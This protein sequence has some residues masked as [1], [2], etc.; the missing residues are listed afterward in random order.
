MERRA[1]AYTII[2]ASALTAIAGAA[3]SRGRSELSEG[4]STGDRR[5]SLASRLLFLAG[6]AVLSGCA[7]NPNTGRNQLMALPA[8]QS[9]HANIAYAISS[10]GGATTVPLCATVLPSPP[11]TTSTTAPSACLSPAQRE[12]FARQVQRI[13]GELTEAAHALAPTLVARFEAFSIAVD[14]EIATGTVSNAGG[15]IALS[16]DL[17]A[18]DP[19]D[20]VVAFLIAREMGH[21]IARH[22][23]ENAGV[24]M[25][26]SAIAT[27]VP[28][29][30]VLRLAASFLGSQIVT[31]NWAEPQRREADELALGLLDL[32]DRSPGV[33]ALNLRAGLNRSRLP[34]GEW[35]T[36]FFQSIDRVIAISRARAIENRFAATK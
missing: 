16:S 34:A 3:L 27:L 18:M 32:C 26:A 4:A 11:I 12:R 7:V 8:A 25:A 10:P 28:I 35:S 36:S 9:A 24:R 15:R 21:V 5:L 2:A 31:T 29:G 6:L 17:A 13:G 30:A 33:I 20:D 19:T 1:L 14:P 23:E 22:G